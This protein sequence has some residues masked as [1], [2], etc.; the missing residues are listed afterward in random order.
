MII[1]QKMTELDISIGCWASYPIPSHLNSYD[2][3]NFI[4]NLCSQ[5]ID[6]SIYLSIIKIQI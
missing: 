6:L 4:I 5:Y 1:D 3:Y 2:L